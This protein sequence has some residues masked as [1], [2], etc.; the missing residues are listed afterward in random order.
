MDEEAGAFYV[1][2]KGDIFGV[3]RSLSDC[4]AQASSSVHDPS[5]SVYKGYFLRKETEEYL[6]SHGLKGA[7]Y[8]ANAAD[9][10]KD[11]FEKH[12]PCPFNQPDGH[13]FLA[14][15][16]PQKLSSQHKS[17]MVMN[18]S[19][20]DTRAFLANKEPQILSS[21]HKSKMVVN[22]LRSCILEF[23]GASKGN[24]GKAG[25]GAILRAENGSVVF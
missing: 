16:E 17:K 4:Q 1:V 6:A 7:L 5:V 10:N 24:P 15:K 18:N 8:T 25:A 11:T 14:D 20:P 13:A 9:V 12:V 19:Q 2:R 21:Q 22:N 23:D 3:Y